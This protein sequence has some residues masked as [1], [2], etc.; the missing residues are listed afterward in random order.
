M[1]QKSL[2]GIAITFFVLAHVSG[3]FA[4]PPRHDRLLYHL[5]LTSGDPNPMGVVT[6]TGGEYSE[7]GWTPNHRSGQLRID[8]DAFLPFEGTLKVT[9]QGMMPVVYDEW[10]PISLYSRGD[11]SFDGVDPT[12]GS[13]IFLKSDDHYDENGLD[14]KFFSSSFYGSNINTKRKDMPIY[15]RTW[16]RTQEYT[17]QI[18]WDRSMVYFLID[19]QEV[20]HM[21]FEGQVESFGYIFLGRDNSYPTTT[22]GVHYKDLKI[23]VG[24]TDYPF[25]NIADPFAEMGHRK[26]GGQG[27]VISD[28]DNNGEE[29]LYVSNFYNNGYEIDNLLYVQKNGSFT[30]E[31]AL[32]N[33]N[34]A[35]YSYQSILGDFDKDSDNDLFVINYHSA[36]YPSEPNHLYMNDGA[37]NFVDKSN[38]IAGNTAL[39]SKGGT[40]LDLENDGDLDLVV[41]NAKSQHQVYVNDGTGRFVV[42][43]RGL[44][45]FRSSGRTYRDATAGD[46]NKDGFQDLV[47]AHATG[48][49]IARNDKSGNFVAGAEL[50]VPASANT[51]TLADID[52]D[53]DLDILVG[54]HTDNAGRV[55]IFR[56]DGNFNF[57]N[58]STLQTIAINT[59][60][61]LPG[62][63]NNDG[64]IDLFAIDKETTGKLY[65]NDGSGKFFEQPNTGVEATF[66]S[67]RGAATWDINDD[68]RLDIYAVAH[69]GTVEDDVTREEKYYNRL[70]SFRNDILGAGNYL[71]VKFVDEYNHV[72]GL[73]NKIYVYQSGQ[74]NNAAALVGY[75]EVLSTSAFLSQS[76]LIQ[77]IGTGNLSIVDVKIVL[78]DGSEKI[79][80]SMST[81][82]T[83]VVS[84]VQ[85]VADRMERDFDE[86][87]TAKAGQVFELAY[88]LYSAENEPVPDHP[89]SFEIVQ[90]NGSL[91]E[92][93]NVSS[94]TVN[95]NQ[96]GRAII[97]WVLGPVAGLD[98]VNQIRVTSSYDGAALSGSPDNFSVIA[99]P[100]TPEEILKAS[101]DAQMGFVNTELTNPL[102]VSVVDE[103]GNGV[104]SH[105]VEFTIV[106]GGGSLKNGSNTATQL[107]INTDSNGNASIKWLLGPQLG[108]QKV[109]ARATQNG[110]ALTHSPL[111]FTAT[112]QQPQRKLAYSSGDGQSAPVNSR[113]TNPF[114]VRLLDADNVPI[115]GEDIKFV[116]TNGGKFS[117]SDSIFAST[118]S[119]GYARATASVGNTVGTLN[120]IFNAYAD[121]ASGSPVVFKASAT[122]GPPSQIVYIDGN[123]QSGP[124]GR[125]LPKALQV[126]VMDAENYP[127]SGHDVQFNVTAGNGLVNGVQTA[128]VKTNDLGIALVKWKL[129]ET[130]GSNSV[131]ATAAGLSAP[132]VNFK[133]EGLVGPPARISKYSGDKQKG[134]AGQPL[135]QY[136][137]VTVTDSFYNAIENHAVDFS[138]LSGGGNLAGRTQVTT[139][140]NAFGQA[141]ALLTMGPS[142]YEQTVQARATN[143]G[144][145]LI[146][147]PV[148]FYAYL[149]PGDPESLVEVS[150]NYQFGAVN[151]ELA[152][153]FVVKVHDENSVG[154][155]NV[156]VEFVTF[157]QG[158]SF[159]GS[160][161]IKVRTNE[162]GFAKAT[163]TLGSNF[164]NNNYVFEAIAK[165]DG[166]HLKG[167]PRQ[168]YASGRRSL[169]KKIQKVDG[170]ENYTGTVGH[171]LGDSLKVL[172]LDE[173]NNPVANHPVTFQV[174]SGLALIN[175]QYTNHI[176]ISNN[177]GVS[178]VRMKMGT[179]PGQSVVRASSDD[180][181]NPLTPAFL[182]FTMLAETGPASAQ[183]STITAASGLVADG[184]SVSDVEIV[185]K[186]EFQN[187]VIGEFVMLQAAGIEV[188]VNQP[189]QPTD[190]N[191]KTNGSITSINVGTAT[192]WA[193]VDNQPL[194]SI[195]VEFV[196]GAPVLA[197]KR[198]D[199]QTGEKGK[200]LQLPIGVVVQDAY[201]HPIENL[202]V[203][204]EVRRGKGTITEQQPVKTDAEGKTMVH[205]TLGDSL[206]QQGVRAYV[207]GM[208]APLDFTAFAIPPS[209]GNVRI[210]SGDSLI[211]IKNQPLP[212][213]FKVRVTD[214]NENPIT[215]IPVE[216]QVITQGGGTWST[217]ARVNTNQ[218]GVA[219]AQ[220]TAGAQL[221]LHQVIA[222]ATNYGSVIF[223][224]MI[225]NERTVRIIKKSPE[226]QTVRPKTELPVTIQVVDSYNRPVN[227]EA[228]NFTQTQGQ[229]FIK[230]NLPIKT[231]AD[232]MLTATWVMGTS[233]AQT[234]QINAV[235]ATNTTTSYT[236]VVV[237]NKP[238]FDPPLP[239]NIATDAGQ[240]VEFYVS[241]VDPDDDP[242]YFI[243]K[244]IPD[245]ATF[246]K[247]NTRKFSW[248]PT[249]AQAGEHQITFLVMD[250]YGASDSSVVNIN[251][252]IRNQPPDIVSFLPEDTLQVIKYNSQLIF[253]INAQDPNGDEVRYNWTVNGAFASD[254]YVLPIVFTRA[255]FPDSFA[256][257][258]VRVYDSNG[259]ERYKTW[260]IHMQKD[261]FVELSN[262]AAQADVNSI[263]LEWQ[264]ATENGTAGFH[265]LKS[266]RRDGPF[267]AISQDLIKSKPDKSYS[268]VDEDV[269]AGQRYFYRLRE[270]DVYGAT[271]E[272][273]LVEAQ[274]AIP[275]ELA[276][277]QNY[278]NPFNPTTT[279]RF[280]LPEPHKVK[281]VLFNTTGQ[282]VRTLVDG[283]YVPGVHQIVW[284]ATND[285]GLRVPSG[286]YYYR[287]TTDNFNRTKKLLLLK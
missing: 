37:G 20:T 170:D 124:A 118:D 51:T 131:V 266:Q 75:R 109:Y 251:V 33:V 265:V 201:S 183:T 205:W 143:N 64:S 45:N 5:P 197:M 250:E 247:D 271:S 26:I 3:I 137:V 107:T 236:A 227:Q 218:D 50:S 69:G 67:G 285:Q 232:G 229:S 57:T 116:A 220:L 246:D 70:Y 96:D 42:E 148:T 122:S 150:G 157:S 1:F 239:R 237:N 11:G 89:V 165:F 273:G 8:L 152:E 43:S 147:S 100:S 59:F 16:N 217:N 175:G 9:L 88:M 244:N 13:Y 72:T 60:G 262:F 249:S 71:K 18:T 248:T 63:W 145:P 30:E 77:H 207:D 283:E 191:G 117:G 181:V 245:D 287:M 53:A 279:I 95:T 138:V 270:L 156:E 66:V 25:T 83:M 185:L 178:A 97:S 125:Y 34:D 35:A 108:Q 202:S 115:S 94:R 28:V 268:F 233:G 58:I 155:S 195:D 98:G 172:V 38:T 99:G 146:D 235:N 153:P 282:L 39:D 182:D 179:R 176:V 17:F 54:V 216:F 184:Q 120:Y 112:A 110:V 286:I 198:N 284:D 256:A 52:N 105:P 210:F 223:N 199:G 151:E 230:E 209:D 136:F 188:L 214:K 149:G 129:G 166:K 6:M 254:T 272:Y 171:F 139:Y 121:N 4:A 141:Q 44:Q 167:S 161:S 12:P 82:Q 49:S 208:T 275:T 204:Y 169:A 240:E 22:G 231:N 127:V 31:G 102:V 119:E 180:G 21:A 36:D 128:T 190:A 264:T 189:P 228:I 263:R 224:Y 46:I 91:D 193:L 23:Y 186:D 162:E 278:P 196:P 173:N 206:G 80:T 62:D 215:S 211:A 160:A 48:L 203:R 134:E 221:G 133:A 212:E 222:T 276:L 234:M 15:S 79:Y 260:R 242:V 267:E 126:K 159:S 68:G 154:V 144:A 238:Y 41:V 29:D 142:D 258:Q 90:G 280:E 261:T 40:M 24:E 87:Q 7:D 158:A 194:I 274:V 225:V 168:F 92:N 252:D 106:E 164:G 226:G 114:V 213:M 255:A 140:T 113:L 65:I 47:I 259:A 2:H 253:Q 73:G 19:G 14:F 135:A 61:V 257:V 55:E 130:V 32:R 174:Q 81:N 187:P 74:L 177:K 192:I 27:V 76:S 104:P 281:I 241:A 111:T 219:S 85:V 10:V 243:A 78:P 103:F 123:N 163:A 132:G 84:P 277:A 101:G 93:S 56:N 269:Q 200:P 86:N